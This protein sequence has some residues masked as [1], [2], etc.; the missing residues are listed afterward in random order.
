MQGSF[1]VVFKKSVIFARNQFYPFLPNAKSLHGY[2]IQLQNLNIS[3]LSC[4]NTH[5]FG[6]KI[7]GQLLVINNDLADAM[8]KFNFIINSKEI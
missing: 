2:I 8:G 6:I 7:D 5:L 3:C 4:E 1:G